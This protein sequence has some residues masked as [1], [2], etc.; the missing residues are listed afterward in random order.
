MNR[1]TGY[2]ISN[3]ASKSDSYLGPKFGNPSNVLCFVQNLD[4]IHTHAH[5][6]WLSIKYDIISLLFV[7]YQNCVPMFDNPSVIC[8]TTR[9]NFYL[10]YPALKSQGIKLLLHMPGFHN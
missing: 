1:P 7:Q 5:T 2:R 8:D 3:L 4:V 6:P 10:R 9:G